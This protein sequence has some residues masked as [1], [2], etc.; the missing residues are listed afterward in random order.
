MARRLQTA[1]ITG[2][3]A[4]MGAEYAR[5]LAA[6][7]T[8]LV[9]TP[10]ALDRLEEL[11][12]ELRRK[13]GVTVEI[14]RPTS[15]P[16]RGSE[17][18]ERRHRG[19]TGPRPPRQQR[20]LRRPGRFR[21]AGRSP[22]TWAWSRSMSARPSGLTRA[23]LPGM[24]ARGRG[25]V[26]NVASHRRLLPVLRADVQRHEGLPGDVLGEPPGR[27][28]GQGD[29]VQALCPGMTHT[30]FH[31]VAAIDKAGR[32]RALL[33]DGRKGRPDLP[34]PARPRR[35]LRPRLEEQGDRLPDALSGHGGRRP[36]HRPER[37]R[38]QEGRE[39]IDFPAECVKMTSRGRLTQ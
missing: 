4:G 34:P 27:A 16:P 36:G 14:F 28:Q 35:R 37:G 25:G 32:P 33:D 24:I 21:R 23:A 18:V 13:H 29:L 17:R 5:Q 30:E 20:R 1:L 3:S 10:G 2:A 11:A 7:G 38:P 19:G 8:N 15:R 31:E 12:R 39:E 9:L 26:I 6:A 22:T